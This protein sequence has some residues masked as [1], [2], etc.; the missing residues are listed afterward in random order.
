MKSI[1][2]PRAYSSQ[3]HLSGETNK[4]TWN[5]GITHMLLKSV[6]LTNNRDTTGC[7]EN[8]V[9][10]MVQSTNGF[11]AEVKKVEHPEKQDKSTTIP[12]HVLP[13]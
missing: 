1:Y 13:I 8:G 4:A 9:V 6:T 11:T 10:D 3:L 2:F 7:V 5:S 12:S